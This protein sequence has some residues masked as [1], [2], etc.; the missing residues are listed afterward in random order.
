M[1]DNGIQ[2]DGRCGVSAGS[3][4]FAQGKAAQDVVE[5][6]QL[7]EWLDTRSP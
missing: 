3:R 5:G 1:F 6:M 4:M 7:A 2:R